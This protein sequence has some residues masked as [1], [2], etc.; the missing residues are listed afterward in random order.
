MSARLDAWARNLATPARWSLAGLA[1]LLNGAAFIDLGPLA[2][3]A[4]VPLLVALRAAPRASLAAGLGGFVG[5]LGGVHIY[6]VLDY[7]WLLFAGFSLYTASQMVL[8]ALLLR[9]LD[10]RA[11]RWFDVALPA[12]VWTLTEWIRTVGPLAMP[13]SY[14]GCIADDAALRPLL[15]LAPVTGGLGVSTL[16]ALTQSAIFHLLFSHAR[17]RAPAAA[18]LGLVIA[19]GIWGAADPPPLGERPITVAAVQGGLVNTQ[20]AAARADAAAM[21]DIVRTYETLT[22]RAYARGVD[23]VVWP[24]TA[25]RAPVLETRGLRDRLFPPAGARSHLVAGLLYEDHDGHTFNL[26]VA[27]EPG[28]ATPAFYAKKRLVPNAE[29]HLTAGPAWRPIATKVGRLG[30][31]ICLESVYP[32]AGRA[33]TAGGAEML[34]VMSN[35]A[36][37]GWSPISRHMIGRAI[38][39]AVENGRWLLRVGQAG[40]T[41]LIDPTGATHGRLGLFVPDVLYGE[42]RLRDDLTLFTRWGDWWMGVVALLLGV[43][44]LLGLRARRAERANAAPAPR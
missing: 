37:F 11:G 44:T 25:V 24:E 12:L 10:G 35:D 28:G 31:L 27:V 19:V 20:Y 21:R 14:V 6:G 29:S 17:H 26:A 41:T 18:A 40:L 7:G 5:L 22:Q 13:A 30:V 15:A 4:N 23:L 9:A 2:L 8:Y 38:V 39:R 32:D 33:L 43:A 1:G 16:V 34:L 36:G 42:A 3:I